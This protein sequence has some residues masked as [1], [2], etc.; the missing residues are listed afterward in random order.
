M[1]FQP[2]STSDFNYERLDA[3]NTCKLIDGLAP[4][5]AIASCDEDPS[6]IEYHDVTG[7]RKIPL[8]TC[9]GG[10]ELELA[11]EAHP[12]PHHQKEF[13]EKHRLSGVGLFF[14]IVLP[15]MGACGVGWYVYNK[16]DGKFG[17]IR[18]GDAGTPGSMFST[19]KPWISYPVALA[20]GLFAVIVA[21]PEVVGAINRWARGR[22]G[23]GAYAPTPSYRS[24]SSFA[25][26]RGEYV[27]VENDEG[28]LLGEESDE[29][30]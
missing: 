3:D 5:P 21:I 13:D 14:A 26:G 29:E 20:A 18:L 23:R 12:C 2:N 30:V 1:K 4:R 7:Y 17:R 25:R 15:I 19:D 27:G 28:E 24:R 22:F 16:W 10:H 11:G 8:S 9:S 6:L